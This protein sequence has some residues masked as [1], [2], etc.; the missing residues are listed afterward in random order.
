MRYQFKHAHIRKIDNK[1][2]ITDLFADP[3]A[4][5]DLVIADLDGDHGLH[6]N[7]VSDRAYFILSGEGVVTVRSEKFDVTALDLVFIPKETPHGIRGRC[8]F[9]IITTPP[10]APVNEDTVA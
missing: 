6:I 8:R 3:K 1:L 5:F 9:A 7:H 2:A 4:P 10:F